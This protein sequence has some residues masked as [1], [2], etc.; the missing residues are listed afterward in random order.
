MDNRQLFL[1]NLAQTSDFPLA[2]EFSY[3]EGSFLFDK[4]Q[5]PYLDLIS[6]ISVSN[7]GH[8]HPKVVK[9]IK[10]QIDKYLHQMVYGEYIQSPQVQLAHALIKTLV[11]YQSLNGNVIDNVYFTNSGTEAVEGALK[12]AKRYSGKSEIIAISNSYHGSTHGALSLGEEHFKRNFRPLLPGIKKI[13]R[14]RFEDLSQISDKTACVIIEPIGAESGIIETELAFMLDLAKKCQET[15]ALLIFDEIQTGFGR[16]GKFWAL[17]HFGFAPDIL[18][19]A[20]G[21]GGGM[22][23]GAFMASQKI[24]S[25]LKDNPIL[26]HITTFGGHPVSCAASLATLN[27]ILDEISFEELEKKGERIKEIFEKHPLVKSVRGKGLMLAAQMENFETLK[28]TIDGFIEKG[29]ITDWFLYCDNAMRIS[30]PLNISNT[31]IDLL[32]KIV[33]N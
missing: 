24:M 30:P 18:L 8:R 11:G 23:I 10:E 13:E 28:K 9:A 20:K 21:M 7:L 1:N 29:L 22:P 4:N 16:T 17:E 19:S 6:G 2:L 3:A 31:E 27:A 25:V 26:G 5:K 15:G 12:L 33:L 14:N 32:E